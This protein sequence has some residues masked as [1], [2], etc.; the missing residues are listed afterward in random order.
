MPPG[1]LPETAVPSKRKQVNVR[2]DAEAE[3]L[4]NQLLVAVSARIG[5]EVS[6][7]DLFRLGLLALKKEYLP[8]EQPKKPKGK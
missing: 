4:M 7:S 5:L 1:T 3:E 2:V 6:Q 8:A